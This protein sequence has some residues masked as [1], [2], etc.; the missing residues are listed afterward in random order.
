MIVVG[1]RSGLQLP[2]ERFWRETLDHIL[3]VGPTVIHLVEIYES[4]HGVLW[5]AIIQMELEATDRMVCSRKDRRGILLRL[6]DRE[7]GDVNFDISTHPIICYHVGSD[8]GRMT[9]ASPFSC[10]E[11]RRK[12]S[13]CNFWKDHLFVG[14]VNP[15]RRCMLI[16][17]NDNYRLIISHTSYSRSSL[18]TYDEK[19]YQSIVNINQEI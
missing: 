19:V 15:L 7:Q 18:M 11:R 10:D 14:S 9:R 16:P 8:E 13:D 2:A 6:Y 5:S 4:A 12:S 3:W 1:L 17:C